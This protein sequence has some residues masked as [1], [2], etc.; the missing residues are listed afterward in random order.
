MSSTLFLATSEA[1]AGPTKKMA[2]FQSSG[3]PPQG[4]SSWKELNVILGLLS[5]SG[6]A[7]VYDRDLWIKHSNKDFFSFYLI[8][9]NKPEMNRENDSKKNSLAHKTMLS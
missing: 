5:N 6:L 2:G 8:D 1:L 7:Q 3:D 4:Q 9:T